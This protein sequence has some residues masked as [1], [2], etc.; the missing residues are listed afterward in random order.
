MAANNPDQPRP[1]AQAPP[2]QDRVLLNPGPSGALV[3]G[4]LSFP[5]LRLQFGRLN[6]THRRFDVLVQ[7]GQLDRVFRAEYNAAANTLGG[8]LA[9]GHTADEHVRMCKTFVLKRLMDIH[10][11]QTGRR[12][13]NVL[14]LARGFNVLRPLGDLLYALGPYFCELNGKKYNLTYT[15]IPLQN[16]PNWYAIDDGI[17]AHYQLLVDQ[18][19]NR[20]DTVPFPKM[21]EMFGQPLMFTVAQT[22]NELRQVRASLNVPTPA[23]AF[24]RFVHEDGL[25]GNANI[26]AFDDCDLIMTETLSVDDVVNRY[27]RSYTKSVH[28]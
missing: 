9:P 20:Y 7:P 21:S 24:L 5:E 13:A 16:P 26:P 17:L 4:L 15:P 8:I 14:N 11:F 25:F 28:G 3:P 1:P 22:A 23:D 6:S 2:T 27:V 10:E 18:C 12:P 19:T